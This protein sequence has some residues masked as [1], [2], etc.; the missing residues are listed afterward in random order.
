MRLRHA[1]GS[2]NWANATTAQP[3]SPPSKPTVRHAAQQTSKEKNDSKWLISI[4][5]ELEYEKIIDPKYYYLVLFDFTD[6][7]DPRTIRASIWRVD[8]KCPGFA[9]CMIDYHENIRSKSRSKAPLNL[10]PFRM[11]FKLM[12]PDLIYRS[13]ISDHDTISTEIFPG[14]N[15]SIRDSIHLPQFLK[16]TNLSIDKINSFAGLIGEPNIQRIAKKKEKLSLIQSLLDKNKVNIDYA[17]D[18]LAESLYWP[19]ISAKIKTLP[20]KLTDSLR[21]ANLI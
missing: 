11:K 3:P 19:E 5:H 16:S 18:K 15:P 6:L 10:W 13:Y 17:T 1:I 4:R 9:F 12:K 20:I 8:P 7:L 21:E 2:I 14:Q